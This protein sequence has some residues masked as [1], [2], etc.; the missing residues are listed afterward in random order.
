M[1]TREDG[2]IF[3][4]TLFRRTACTEVDSYNLEEI[5]LNLM[6]LLLSIS[7]SSAGLPHTVVSRGLASHS[8]E[9]R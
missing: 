1:I 3:L 9:G 7:P 6:Y 5:S 8:Q 4:L 2:Y